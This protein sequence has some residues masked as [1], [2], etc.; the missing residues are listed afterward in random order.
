MKIALMIAAALALA[1]CQQNKPIAELSYSE[2]KE[3]AGVIRQRCEAQGVKQGGPEWDAC[4]KQEISRESAT[5]NRRAAAIASAANSGPTVC[6]TIGY[7]T[8]CN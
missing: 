2:V 3:L 8:I 6:N 5:R 7:T 1:G 4:T